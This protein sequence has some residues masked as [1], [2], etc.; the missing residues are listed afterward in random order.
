MKTPVHQD[1][2]GPSD[3]C[4]SLVNQIRFGEDGEFCDTPQSNRRILLLDF[5][6][7]LPYSPAGWFDDRTARTR[8]RSCD[9]SPL[10]FFY[11]PSRQ[12][13]QILG[14]FHFDP[15]S[16]NW[17]SSITQRRTKMNKK[18]YVGN[19]GPGVGDSDLQQLFASHGSILSAKVVMDK[20][21][22]Q[23]KGFGFVEMGTDDEARAAMT[24]LNGKDHGGSVLKV[25][26]AKSKTV[27]A[28]AHSG[29]APW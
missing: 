16:K 19:L 25:D 8:D 20:K 4:D 23:S 22:N 14:P 28:T 18:L 6:Y 5:V 7:P 26:E 15:E 12:L 27:A 1:S 11:R 21:T 13:V 24:S 3:G 29:S 17:V 9:F 2:H 10:T